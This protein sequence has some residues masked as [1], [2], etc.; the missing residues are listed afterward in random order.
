MKIVTVVGARP[1]FVKAAVLSRAIQE[2]EG[3]EEVLVHT[4]QH[5]DKNMSNIFFSEMRI[6]KPNYHFD[7]NGGGH[8]EMTGK[9]LTEIEGVLKIEKP[10]YLLVYGDTNSTLAGA[11][12][13]AK[14][15]IPVAH[16]EAGLRS[17]NMKMPEEINRILTD[18]ISNYLFC[19]T[20]TAAENLKKEGYDVLDNTVI[21]V[22]DIMYEAALF[23]E[24]I[25]AESSQIL[26][27][28][29]LE[30]G[31]YCL[32]TIHRQE[33]TDD[34]TNLANIVSAFN[35]IQ[36][37]MDIV[38]PL[39]PRTAKLIKAHGLEVK[40]KVIEPV[41]YLDM[42]SLIKGAKIVLTDSG[43]LQKEAY[44]FRKKCITMREQTEWVE[45]V[46]GGVNILAG[47]NQDRIEQAFIEFEGKSVNFDQQFYG[48]G[49]TSRLILQQ[50][51]KS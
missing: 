19:P 20:E 10:D 34:S 7:I 41:G 2:T 40:F 23:Y 38:V 12:A 46:K 43:G 21:V 1:Q 24:K 44:F 11:L 39:H 15:H 50:L 25:A 31:A 37:R 30:D 4:G 8:G 35:S 29:G 14:L 32:A 16:V 13:A 42:I 22:G 33:N 28:I 48:N 45:L 27:E 17:F 9:M 51:A 5:F 3:V 49:D 47:A 26:H 18:R 6:P 36:E